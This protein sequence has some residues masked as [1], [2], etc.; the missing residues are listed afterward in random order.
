MSIIKDGET[1]YTSSEVKEKLKVS[2]RA[3]AKNI[4]REI[5]SEIHSKETVD[6]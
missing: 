6:V 4:A 3:K 5:K 1:Y 2:V